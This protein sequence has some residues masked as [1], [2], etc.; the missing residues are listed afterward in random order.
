[1]QYPAVEYCLLVDFRVPEAKPVVIVG[2]DGAVLRD[3]IEEVDPRGLHHLDDV[4]V[5]WRG[6]ERLYNGQIIP[7]RAIIVTINLNE[8]S[9]PQPKKNK[10]SEKEEKLIREM[11]HTSFYIIQVL[12]CG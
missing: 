11:S 4:L 1:M 7:Q 12:R 3:D 2:E 6:E 5:G 10:R 8:M 9:K